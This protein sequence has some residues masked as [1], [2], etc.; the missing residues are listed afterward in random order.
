[1]DDERVFRTACGKMTSYL[2][3]VIVFSGFHKNLK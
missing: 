3:Y 1:M 2:R